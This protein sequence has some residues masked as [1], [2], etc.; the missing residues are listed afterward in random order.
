[1]E[2]ISTLAQQYGFTVI[3]DASHAI[4][5]RY[6]NTRIGSCSFSDMT[7]LSFHPVK[8]ITTGEGG[9]ILT[10]NPNLYQ[11]L[12][13]LRSHGIT[14]DPARMEGTPDGSWY[15]QQV[16]LGFNYRMTDIQA[17]LGTSQMQ[18]IDAF[19]ARRQYLAQRYDNLLTDLPVSLPSRCD[20]AHSAYHLYVI[21]L[22]LNLIQKSHKQVFEELR[23]NG[24]GVNLH[25][26]PV[27][28]HPYYQRLGFQ[29]GDFPEAEQ[30]YKEAISLPMFYGLTDSDQDRVLT[31]MREV[32]Q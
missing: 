14:R 20:Y 9:M 1:M 7:V 23:E 12:V 16:E 13:L 11:R 28:M 10:N 18:R 26:I 31:V 4:G 21:R 25:Y 30:Y 27:H 22:R 19:V 24:I 15:Y 29:R 6:K 3:E 17:A 8:I 5:G 32:L 2:R